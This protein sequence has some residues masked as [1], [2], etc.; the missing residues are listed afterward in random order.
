[1]KKLIEY[2]SYIQEVRIIGNKVKLE[3]IPAEIVFSYMLGSNETF[4]FY[5]ELK[6]YKDKIEESIVKYSKRQLN[7]LNNLKELSYKYKEIFNLFSKKVIKYRCSNEIIILSNIEFNT[8]N[9]DLNKY[10]KD[11]E[12]DFNDEFYLKPRLQNDYNKFSI[13][14]SNIVMYFIVK[15]HFF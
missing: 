8:I 13:K 7:D 4:N 12:N 11:I 2:N 5:P 10:D 15:I 3:D 14:T 1:M 6:S 9:D